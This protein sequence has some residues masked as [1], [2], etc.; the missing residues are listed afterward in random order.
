MRSEAEAEGGAQGEAEG[1]GGSNLLGRLSTYYGHTHY[2]VTCAA[3]T[4][5]S[6]RLTCAPKIQGEYQALGAHAHTGTT[7]TNQPHRLPRRAYH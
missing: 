6:S 2:G 1:E 5:G 7:L 4:F 3:A